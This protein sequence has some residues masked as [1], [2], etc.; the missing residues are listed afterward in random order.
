[1]KG[2]TALL[3]IVM[4]HQ[5]HL[6]IAPRKRAIKEVEHKGHLGTIEPFPNDKFSPWKK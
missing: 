6:K 5:S 4:R 2:E 3:R 1:M